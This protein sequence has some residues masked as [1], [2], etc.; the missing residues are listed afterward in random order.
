VRD[1]SNTKM[2]YKKTKRKG[3]TNAVSART[4]SLQGNAIG[5]IPIHDDSHRPSSALT[6]NQTHLLD[7]SSTSNSSISTMTGNNKSLPDIG[8][9]LEVEN[10]FDIDTLDFANIPVTE[11]NFDFDSILNFETPSGTTDGDL[12]SLERSPES[13]PPRSSS[14][15]SSSS[16]V[17]T[18]IDQRVCTPDTDVIETDEGEEEESN[19]YQQVRQFTS[20]RKRRRGPF[21]TTEEREGAAKTRQ[22]GACVRCKAQKIKAGIFNC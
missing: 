16:S 15:H 13:H 1:E 3:G 4:A 21:R 11:F 20:S 14:R 19:N 2:H 22:I 6:I 5:T 7:N 10:E 17:S 8:S 18:D 9:T 12:G